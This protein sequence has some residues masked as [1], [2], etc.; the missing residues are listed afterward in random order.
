VAHVISAVAVGI[1]TM[2][3]PGPM[4]PV[5]VVGALISAASLSAIEHRIASLYVAFGLALGPA[6]WMV[7]SDVRMRFYLGTLPPILLV[8]AV[9]AAL[10]R[11]GW[12]PAV[13]SAVAVVTMLLMNRDAY[14]HRF[15]NDFFEADHVVRAVV[16]ISTLIS[17]SLLELLCGVAIHEIPAPKAKRK[18]KAKRVAAELE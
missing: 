6:F 10:Q 2:Q 12:I 13:F 15:D 8:G 16:I 14:V 18:K 5:V 17:L 1:L 4:I 9:A 11:P 7:V 3:Y